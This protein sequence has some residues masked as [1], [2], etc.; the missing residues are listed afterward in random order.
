MLC[1]SASTS[2][3]SGSA[4]A[5]RP[6]AI[7]ASATSGRSSASR[8]LPSTTAS[9]RPRLR[10]GRDRVA[11][12][13]LELGADGRQPGEGHAQAQLLVDRTCP[14]V[15]LSR[16]VEVA[17]HCL[18]LCQR[19]E[20]VRLRGGTPVRLLEERAAA[21]GRLRRRR[22][23]VEQP[24]AETVDRPRLLVCVTGHARELDGERGRLDR[25]A[26]VAL[27]SLD[28]RHPSP[29]ESEGG[30]VVELAEDRDRPLRHVAQLVARA[31]H[32]A[33]GLAVDAREPFRTQ[34]AD[35][36]RIHDREVQRV[37]APLVLADLPEAATKLSA[38]LAAARAVVGED[39]RGTFEEGDRRRKVVACG[40]PS[41]R[42]LEQGCGL[43]SEPADARCVP[44]ELAQ[45]AAGLL[46]VV[47]CQVVGGRRAPGLGE[48][49]AARVARA[50]LP[51]ASS[52]SGRRRRRGQGRAR[53]GTDPPRRAPARA[54]RGPRA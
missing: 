22:R 47:A 2:A 49:P 42:G 4:S 24:G 34:V 27:A 9:P 25:R 3:R 14:G 16:R 20:D 17:E 35:A 46:E 10:L 26:V 54:G 1:A 13:Q 31:E 18:E 48:E 43:L 41:T 39:L 53:T 33:E 5:S 11:R 28:E 52:G 45:R 21:F 38:D 23:A 29:R 8:P 7:R 51:A 32:Q 19:R 44:A 6:C 30:V 36:R 12:E 50:G 40:R 15:C 37:Q